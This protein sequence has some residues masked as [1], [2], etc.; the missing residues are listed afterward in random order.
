VEA[1]SKT[2]ASVLCSKAWIALRLTANPL[3][4]GVERRLTCSSETVAIGCPPRQHQ[5]G[6]FRSVANARWRASGTKPFVLRRRPGSVNR[7]AKAL[8]DR[9]ACVRLSRHASSG[10]ASGPSGK[11]ALLNSVWAISR[12]ADPRAT[13]ER[14]QCKGQQRV[15]LPRSGAI[16]MQTRVLRFARQVHLIAR[17]F[18]VGHV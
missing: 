18:R 7:C 9:D 1:I 16:P 3:L 6:V 14:L 4:A 11:S 8:S 2:N 15:A 10:A 13:L 5:A 17:S 12:S